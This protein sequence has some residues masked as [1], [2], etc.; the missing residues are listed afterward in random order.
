[1]LSVKS[2]TQTVQSNSWF[3]PDLKILCACSGGLDSS[4]LLH[5]L[6]SL[7]QVEI[8]IIHLNHEL[9]GQDSISD[10]NFV[11]DLGKLY[12]LPVFTVSQNIERH[13]AEN[14]LSLEEAGSIRR[15]SFFLDT[16]EK[17]GYDVVASAQHADD[18]IETILMNLYTGTGIRGLTGISQE[19]Q[20]IVRPL[21]SFS[22]AE[23]KE[24]AQGNQLQY[25]HDKTNAETKFLR[26]NIRAEL[27]PA[28]QSLSD[29]KIRPLIQQIVD[30]G[31]RLNDRVM[32]SVEHNDNN[33]I[34]THSGAKISLGL[35]KLP[36]YFSPIQKPIFD[37]AFQAISSRTQGLS[38]AHFI[39]LKSLFSSDNIGKE[40]QLPA[41]ITAYRDRCSIS[42]LTKEYY[43]WRSRNL[44]LVDSETC[45]FMGIDLHDHPIHDHVR[46]P[47]YFWLVEPEDNYTLRMNG[48]GDRM[49]IDGTGKTLSVNQI[50]Q[51]AHIAPS[52]KRFF[53]VMEN[54]QEI[55]WIPG[56]RT[57]FSAMVDIASI[58]KNEVK[59]CIKVQFDE[60]TFE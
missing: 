7:P 26:N 35:E 17:L 6:T 52:M 27:I 36:D 45:P 16:L 38:E 10:M 40:I 29:S 57:S 13:A 2:F 54:E 53:P 47:Y 18:Q 50:L 28:M 8:S 41:S 60:G 20:N 11:M 34:S 30:H 44:S 3:K 22:R 23:I 31:T 51:E 49:L 19:W 12:D 21:L 25:R 56:I 15:K 46:D 55:V 33:V 59:H 43:M 37:R 4:V 24:Y 32:R 1:M 48:E 5:L 14:D 39:E 9:R 58:D 42:F